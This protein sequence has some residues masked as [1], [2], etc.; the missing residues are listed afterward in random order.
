MPEPKEKQPA[1][2]LYAS[3]RQAFR[4]YHILEKI[5]AGLALMGAEVKSIRGSRVSIDEGYASIDNGQAFLYSMHVQP[6][7]H[8][9]NETY[10]PVRPRRLLLHRSQINRLMGQLAVKGCTLIPLKLYLQ[11]GCIKIEL[12]LAKGKLHED[13]RED[14]K[15]KETDREMARAV[16]RN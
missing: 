4:D 1:G 11:H 13:R 12:G 6:Y 8:C 3:N 14:L 15:K 7:E 10:D 16:R 5:E 9:R 2:T